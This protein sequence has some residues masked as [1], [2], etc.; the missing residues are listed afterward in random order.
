ML[1]R[2]SLIIPVFFF[3]FVAQALTSAHAQCLYSDSLNEGALAA[4][5]SATDFNTALAGAG[6][7]TEGTAL[8]ITS[9]DNNIVT[10][11]ASDSFHFVYQEASG[12]ADITLEIDSAPPQINGKVGIMMR[13]QLT[14]NSNFAGIFASTGIDYLFKYRTT[15]GGNSVEVDSATLSQFPSY[16]QLS[17][18]GNVFSAYYSPDGAAWTLVATQSVTMAYPYYVGIAVCAANSTTPGS[19]VVNNFAVVSGDSCTSTPTPTNT[20][21]DTPTPTVTPTPSP[22]LT[23][24]ITLSPTQTQNLSP[25]A[26]P[27]KTW[28]RTPTSTWTFTYSYTPA[29]TFSFTVTP[30]MTLSPTDSPT[31]TP[32]ITDTPTDTS[33]DTPSP[34]DTATFTDTPSPT[35]TNTWTNTNTPSYTPTF[36]PT[37]TNTATSTSTDTMTYTNTPSY[38]PTNTFTFTYTLTFTPTPTPTPTPTVYLT[39]TFT[40][41]PTSTPN[42]ALYL[43]AN[44][45]NPDQA[46]LGMDVRVDQGGGVN[47]LVFNLAGEEVRK[48]KDESMSAGNYRSSWDGKNNVGAVVGNGVYFIIIDQPSGRT[49][50]K[51]VVLR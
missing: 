10:G 2:K 34:T 15:A 32:T 42:A 31:L 13:E 7:Q 3:G 40:L 38:T 30:T 29:Y 33:T 11:S 1:M 20:A 12:D 43:D 8:T 21:T 35:P 37:P 22:T 44:F 46:P 24:T 17:R 19:G 50:R 4:F 47:I 27:T 5:W 26:T 36:T 51:A 16:V 49:T 6:T 48:I 23:P 18:S 25:T 28:T 39:P 41:S 14:T 45:F 9:A